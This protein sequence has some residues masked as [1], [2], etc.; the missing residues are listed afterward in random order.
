MCNVGREGCYSR[1]PKSPCGLR[2]RGGKQALIAAFE[3]A[4]RELVDGLFNLV[5]ILMQQINTGAV[6][7]AQETF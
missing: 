7:N 2:R 4:E 6:F 1:P 3:V 5:W